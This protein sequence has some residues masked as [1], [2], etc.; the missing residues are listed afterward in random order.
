MDVARELSPH[1]CRDNVYDKTSFE[2][3]SLVMAVVAMR[4][5]TRLY[6]HYE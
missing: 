2:G 3:W 1:L 4:D 5:I 6:V